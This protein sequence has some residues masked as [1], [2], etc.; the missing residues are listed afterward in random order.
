MRPARTP[1]AQARRAL[2]FDVL[3]AAILAAVA[4]S[5]AAGLGVIAFF[6]VPVVLI[7]LLWVGLERALSRLRR[8]R[9]RRA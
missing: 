1:G 2:A 4:L 7:G 3:T 9:M 8:R 5:I 6:A